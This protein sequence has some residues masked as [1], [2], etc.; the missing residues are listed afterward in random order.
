MYKLTASL[1]H[2]LWE[3]DKKLVPLVMLGHGELITEEM[4]NEYIEWCRTDEGR[5]YLEGGS[6]Y[7]EVK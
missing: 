2:W 7:R 3:Y 1:E 5:E 6:K 4:W